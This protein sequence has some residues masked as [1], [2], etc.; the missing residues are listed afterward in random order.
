VSEWA[1]G[2]KRLARR[3]PGHREREEGG[4]E[5]EERA[6]REGRGREAERE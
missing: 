1:A 5:Q 3:D 4:R 2:P 6:E